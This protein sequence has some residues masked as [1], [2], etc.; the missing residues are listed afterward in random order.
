MELVVMAKM[1]LNFDRMNEADVREEFIAPLLAELGY[2]SGSENHAAREVPLSLR[3]PRSFLGKKNPKSDPY[4]RG[5]ADYILEV[6]GHA[7][8]VMEAKPPHELIDIDAIEQ[9]WS[10]ANHPEVRAVY[11]AISNGREFRVYVTTAPPDSSPILSI[12]WED[13]ERDSALISHLLSA[14]A[15]KR[16]FPR[17]QDMGVPLGPG[18]QSLAMIAS[19]SIGYT[20]VSI[21][22][23]IIEELQIAV[24]DGAIERGD[25]GNLIAYV[26]TQ[27]PI[28]S[29]QQMI[30]KMGLS[31]LEYTSHST[32]LSSNPEFPTN[33]AYKGQADFARGEELFDITSNARVKLPFS[34]RCDIESEARVH[35]K[36]GRILGTIRN[37]A[38]YSGGMNREVI[39]SGGIALRVI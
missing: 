15:I 34:I 8:W 28:R 1:A 20:E 5:R 21:P 9:A 2:R 12:K 26:V 27:A 33:F 4:V 11:F 38:A 17:T 39:F 32:V 6:R 10:Y 30:E 14:E 19:G 25:A 18:L 23:P 7:R 3:Y 35:V 37:V 22:M 16:N 24:I 29:I 36:D 31:K 13:M